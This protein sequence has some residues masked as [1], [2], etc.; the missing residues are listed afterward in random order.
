MWQ[1]APA[2]RSSGVDAGGER[3]NAN[4]FVLEKLV[5]LGLS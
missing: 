2:D 3:F 1:T 5:F 4:P